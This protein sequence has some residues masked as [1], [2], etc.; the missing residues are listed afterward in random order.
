MGSLSNIF[1]AGSN[2]SGNTG[3]TLVQPDEDDDSVF[4]IIE[5]TALPTTNTSSSNKT[6][7]R[8]S[9]SSST[10]RT[11]GNERTNTSRETVVDKFDAQTRS[12]Y[13]QLLEQL[14]G[15][16]TTA[17]REGTAALQSLLGR[18]ESAEQQYTSDAARAQAQQ[19]IPSY[20]RELREEIMPSVLSAQEGAGMSGDALTALLSQDQMTRIAEKAA[21]AEL[22]AI[23][24]FGELSQ[25]QQQITGGIA[26]T[27]ADDP[28]AASLQSLIDIGKGAYEKTN[29]YETIQKV[30]D[31]V[32]QTDSTASETLTEDE[33]AYENQQYETIGGSENS[34]SSGSNSLGFNDSR[35]YDSE[36]LALLI[37]QLGG[38]Q[39]LQDLG[40]TST[41]DS[42][43]N[44][45]RS[46]QSIKG[47]ANTLG[48]RL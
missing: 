6:G 48:V 13:G 45:S 34:G 19:S 25:G 26:D 36:N 3:Y 46:A 30:I 28:V 23:E 10:A 20:A 11:T 18:S 32:V 35:S 33:D 4:Q 7:T 39:S 17:Q 15:G 41:L 24:A 12:A 43:G 44:Q 2:V 29:T 22:A 14:V 47:L 42:F 38:E 8:N 16:G 9:Q 40:F 37:S 1:S 27:L 21:N 31:S 5:P